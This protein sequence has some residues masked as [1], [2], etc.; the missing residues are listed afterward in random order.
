MR[1]KEENTNVEENIEEKCVPTYFV[2]DNFANS[3][4]RNFCTQMG[5]DNIYILKA[6]FMGFVKIFMESAIVQQSYITPK[7]KY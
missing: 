6:L 1:T 7:I 3:F 4:D 2:F 5:H